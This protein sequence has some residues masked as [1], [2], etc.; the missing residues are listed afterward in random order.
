MPR[1]I[2]IDQSIVDI[3]GHHYEYAQHVLS[4]AEAAGYTPVLAAHQQFKSTKAPW[5][6]IPVYRLGFWKRMSKAT[7]GERLANAYK[8]LYHHFF[9]WKTRLFFSQLGFLWIVRNNAVEYLRW[10]P[11]DSAFRASHAVIL[12]VIFLPIRALFRILGAI[13]PFQGFFRQAWQAIWSSVHSA[14]SL[15]IQSTSDGGVLR[16]WRFQRRKAR[17]FAADTLAL[18]RTLEPDEEDLVFVPTLGVPEMLGLLDVWRRYPQ[19]AKSS[20]HLLFRR[21]L[22]DGRE[23]GFARQDELLTPLRNAFL[24]FRDKA[25]GTR[26]YFYT[27]TEELSAQHERVSSLPFHTC[28]IPHTDTPYT[29]EGMA[30]ERPLQMVY[31]GDA[32]AEKGYHYFPDLVEDMRRDYLASG[33]VEFQI[34]SNYNIPNGES[35]AVV[36][37]CLLQNA[38]AA[39]IKLFLEPLPSEQYRAVL[40]QADLLILPYDRDNYY[41]RSSGV[42]IEALT[43][44]IPVVAPSGSWLG[45]QFADGVYAYRER[46]RTEAGEEFA[47]LRRHQQWQQAGTG[48]TWYLG[49]SREIRF[50][51]RDRATHAWVSAPRGAAYVWVKIELETPGEGHAVQVE[52]LEQDRTG[53]PRAES[54]EVLAPG[55][56]GTAMVA[57]LPIDPRSAKVKIT[58][59]HA[60]AEIELTS[61]ELEVG[62]LLREEGAPPLPL[63]AIGVGY[64]NVDKL[65][66][67]VKEVVEH[68][69][70][71]RGTAGANA[72]AA[73]GFHNAG[74]LV[75]MLREQAAQSSRPRADLAGERLIVADSRV[76]A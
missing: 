58:L 29:W 23:W 62:F 57:M 69:A 18:L 20:Y 41:A 11:F 19:A 44:G 65:S 10:H 2:L 48:R 38:S 40:R 8:A 37:R 3:G 73:Y 75:S 63:S 22:Y 49:S 52:V 60:F 1:F 14:L 43:A 4:A 36:A 26:V 67:A 74:R 12:A 33:R 6:V 15:A 54:V 42:L 35:E 71:Y 66:W 64:P 13:L 30:A 59:R 5:K 25:A 56:A 34:Q 31:L 55:Y 16:E 47:L 39:G 28:P 70:H 50:G 61:R 21:N 76:G 9:V 72:P 32:R 68:Y 17:L 51:G 7:L 46:L 27:D 24:E 53:R 45:R